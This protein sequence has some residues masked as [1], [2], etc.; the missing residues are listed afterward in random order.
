MH[1]LDGKADGSY[2]CNGESITFLVFWSIVFTGFNVLHQL[3]CR[4]EADWIGLIS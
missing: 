3:A 2:N 1:Q 4:A